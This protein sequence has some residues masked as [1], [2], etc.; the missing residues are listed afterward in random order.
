[1]VADP[2]AIAVAGEWFRHAEAGRGFWERRSLPLDGRWQRGEIV[3]A[4]YLASDEDT[5]WGEWYRALAEYGMPPRRALPRDLWRARVALDRV[6]DLRSKRALERVGLSL[7]APGSRDW[8][9]FQ[10]VGHRL[11]R[12][13]YRGVVAPSAARP[14]GL[15]L[16]LFLGGPRVAG[17]RPVGRP[18]RVSEPPVP[19][20]GMRT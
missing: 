14:S 7:P 17:V 18:R 4:L 19:P 9:A 20:T 12:E 5:V 10:E 11:W 2:R 3:D 6:A 8:P 13:G 16:C 15:S 1:V